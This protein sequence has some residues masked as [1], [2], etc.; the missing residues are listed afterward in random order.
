MTS[1]RTSISYLIINKEWIRENYGKTPGTDVKLGVSFKG[2][3]KV[4]FERHTIFI[5]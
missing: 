1:K 4:N 3:Q 2:K 5:K